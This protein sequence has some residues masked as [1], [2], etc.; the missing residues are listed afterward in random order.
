MDFSRFFP[1]EY[2]I[3]VFYNEDGL[4]ESLL[5]YSSKELNQIGVIDNN[6]ESAKIYYED[7]DKTLKDMYGY[8]EFF[9]AENGTVRS[10]GESDLKAEKISGF[11]K[12]YIV[13]ADGE[14][15]HT[16]DRPEELSISCKSIFKK[17]PSSHDY[18]RPSFSDIF[19]KRS[20][21]IQPRFKQILKEN[22]RSDGIVFDHI[23][24]GVAKVN[25]FPV[26]SFENFIYLFELPNG[27][28]V[29][30]AYAVFKY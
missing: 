22:D 24:I 23:L 20:I 27:N 6:R 5:K 25:F 19:V 21:I 16:L 2:T 11:H 18:L 3:E 1:K 30:I 12:Y 7:L 17:T 10:Y 14:V 9:T 29:P 28:L 13:Q 4:R 15:T 8:E 26:P